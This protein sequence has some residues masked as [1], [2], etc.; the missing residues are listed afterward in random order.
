MNYIVLDL[1]ATCYSQNKSDFQSEIIEIGAVKVN[2]QLEIVSTFDAFVRPILNPELSY[3]CKQLTTITQEDIDGAE[4]FDRVIADFANFIGWF[5]RE[6]YWLIGWGNYDKQQLEQD[7]ALHDMSGNWLINYVNLKGEFSRMRE[8]K[9]KYGLEKACKMLGIEMEGTHH[10][11]ID[12]AINT[13]KI[14][15]KIYDRLGL[16]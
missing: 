11:G 5:N 7:C 14:F 2:D 3:F 16:E 13:A 6:P 15:V 8:T 9:R 10:R 1:E 12:D 4:T